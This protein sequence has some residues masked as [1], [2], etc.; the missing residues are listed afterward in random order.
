MKIIDLSRPLEL[1]TPVFAGYPPFALEVIQRAADSTAEGRRLN[2]SVMSMGLHCGTHVDSPLHFY[3][4][5]APIAEV[6]LEWFMGP[7]ILIDLEGKLPGG[8]IGLERLWP[9][10]NALRRTH[11]VLLRTGYE[12]HWGSPEYFTAHPALTKESAEFLVSMGVHLVGVDTPSVDHPPW[13]A[14]LVLLGANVVILEN[15][16]NLSEIAEAPFEIAALP[17]KIARG[18]ASPVRA[19]AIVNGV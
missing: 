14:H 17:L 13:P 19:V 11:K 2:S 12:A 3:D 7:C 4:Q 6:P 1:E 10:E 5:T 16:A 9:Y 18:E 8:F 15:L